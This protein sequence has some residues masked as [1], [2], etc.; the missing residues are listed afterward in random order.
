MNIFMKNKFF[1]LMKYT[2]I[3]K[4][5]IIVTITVIVTIALLGFL[6]KMCARNLV[7]EVPND[8]MIKSEFRNE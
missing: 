5:T 4:K 1:I 8:E 6:M 2:E 7:K 3:I